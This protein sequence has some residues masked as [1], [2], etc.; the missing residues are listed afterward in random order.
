MLNAGGMPNSGT[1]CHDFRMIDNPPT[2]KLYFLLSTLTKLEEERRKAQQEEEQEQ[3]KRQR[4]MEKARKEEDQKRAEAARKVCYQ[5][6]GCLTSL[7]IISVIPCYT[8]AQFWFHPRL[9]P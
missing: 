2:H 4:M 5:M 1:T 9:S 8:I 7:S 3:L 6:G